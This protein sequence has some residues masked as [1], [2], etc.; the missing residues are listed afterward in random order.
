MEVFAMPWPMSSE[1]STKPSCTDVQLAMES[2]NASLVA[3]ITNAVAQWE[4]VGGAFGHHQRASI[5]LDT[6]DTLFS[7]TSDPRPVLLGI[8]AVVDASWGDVPEKASPTNTAAQSHIVNART[9]PAWDKVR[10]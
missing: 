7:D 5:A 8:R 9:N 1:D 6:W 2:V 4:S 10:C 3:K